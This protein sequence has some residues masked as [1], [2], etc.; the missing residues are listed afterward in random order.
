MTK[1]SVLC[2]AQIL[3]AIILLASI[4]LQGGGV[5][6]SSSFGGGESFK[7]RRG[8]EKFLFFT[9]IMAAFLFILT[10]FASLLVR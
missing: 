1:E 9:T 4:L 5:G 10:V 8:V 6:L 7:T 2:L 3:A